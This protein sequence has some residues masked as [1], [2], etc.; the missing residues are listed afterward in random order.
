VVA[1]RRTRPGK[2]IAL[3]GGELFR[4][5]LAAGI[6]DEVTVS[7]I[8]VLLCGRIPLPPSPAARVSLKPR[9]HRV[10]EKT[11]T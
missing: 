10:Y 5:L 11:R 8:P 3:F 9:N 1:D 2:D 7:L 4:S 6:V